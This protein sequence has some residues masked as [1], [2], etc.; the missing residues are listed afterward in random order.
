MTLS[1]LQAAGWSRPHLFAEPETEIPA[2]WQHLPLTL[3][4][5]TRGAFPNWYLALTEMFMTEPHA[6]AYFLC[7][8]DVLFAAGLREYLERRLWPAPQA[9]VV[10]VYC[11]SHYAVGLPVG[12]H[13]E[14]RGSNTWGALAYIFPNPSV[15]HFLSSPL[16]LEHRFRGRFGGVKQIDCVVGEWCL[17]SELPYFVHTPSLV[18][19]LGDTS[20]VS[21][22]SNTGKRRADRFVADVR[23]I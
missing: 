3:R 11:P 16:A 1:S 10:S 15:R 6:D 14:N 19:H 22:S 5:E 13:V 8:D 9:G 12:F 21:N 18:Q 20:T 17:N 2:K 23:D 7:Q 4:P